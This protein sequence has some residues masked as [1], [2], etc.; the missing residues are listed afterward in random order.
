MG[1]EL[2][3]TVK[4]EVSGFIGLAAGVTHWVYGCV[5]WGVQGKKLK[6]DG[7]PTDLQWFDER[8]LL[9]LDEPKNPPAIEFTG[10]PR[11]METG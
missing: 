4:D 11:P 6:E 9:V 2:G 7:T 10:G 1:L 5:R 3:S 8:Q